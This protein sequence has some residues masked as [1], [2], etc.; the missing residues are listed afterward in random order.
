[1][2]ENQ[3]DFTVRWALFSFKGRIARQSFWI[4]ALLIIAVQGLI[5]TRLLATNDGQESSIMWAIT[6]FFSWPISIWMGLALAV[7]RL[8]DIN[9]SAFFAVL[10]FFPFLSTLLLLALAFVPSDREAN[11]HGAPPFPRKDLSSS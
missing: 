5:L 2:T 6:L 4:G 3:T 8:H 9:A 7:K 1:M 11:K 10:M